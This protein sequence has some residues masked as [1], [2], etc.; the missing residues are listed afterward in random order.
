MI[1]LILYKSSAIMCS[2]CPEGPANAEPLA[3]RITK[4]RTDKCEFTS[5]LWFAIMVSAVVFHVYYLTHEAILMIYH[6]FSTFVT[7]TFVNCNPIQCS[8]F[9]R[10]MQAVLSG[11]CEDLGIPFQQQMLKYVFSA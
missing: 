4:Y 6:R 7:T 5:V 10:L 9:A 1:D 11:L 2:L 3:I 8:L